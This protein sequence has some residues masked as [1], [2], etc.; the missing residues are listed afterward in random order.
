MQ[1][2]Q[3]KRCHGCHAC[4]TACARMWATQSMIK[5]H[6][7]SCSPLHKRPHPSQGAA[8]HHSSQCPMAAFQSYHTMCLTINGLPRRPHHSQCSVTA[9]REHAALQR[10]IVPCL[11]RR[12]RSGFTSRQFRHSR[13]SLASSRRSPFSCTVQL[14]IVSE[15]EIECVTVEIRNA[16]DVK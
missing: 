15:I 2:R 3:S 9:I 10:S 11:C 7:A 5:R 6:H 1:G 14:H 13:V 4:P 16:T 8:A 12:K